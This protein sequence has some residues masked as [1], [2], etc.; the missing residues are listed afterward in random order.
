MLDEV[1]MKRVTERIIKLF[2]ALFLALLG[3]MQRVF[4]VEWHHTIRQTGATN[5][6]LALSTWNRW[7][8]WVIWTDFR[9]GSY[10]IPHYGKRLFCIHCVSS[11]AQDSAARL[12]LNTHMSH[13]SCTGSSLN[14][15]STFGIG[16]WPLECCMVIRALLAMHHTEGDKAFATLELS[17]SERKTHLYEL[18][19]VFT[20]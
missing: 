8:V 15:D 17:P 7:L 4:C 19:L 14:S 13:S 6:F 12:L 5:T 20:F 1:A 18:A 11:V 10:F 2:T 16:F 9:K 3:S